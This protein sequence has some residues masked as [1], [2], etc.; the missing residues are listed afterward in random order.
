MKLKYLMILAPALA[1]ATSTA[2]SADLMDVYREAQQSDP[3]IKAALAAYQAT[4]TLRPQAKAG[5]L[6]NIGLGADFERHRFD[7]QTAT[8]G[9]SY[10]NDKSISL[11][12]RQP[13]YN[14]ERSVALKQADANIAQANAQYE[15]ARQSLA[16]RAAQGYFNVLAAR[17]ELEYAQ[18]EKAATSRQLEQSNK[19]F[20]VGMIAITDVNQT[21]AAYDAAVAA[22]ISA[23]NQ[24]ANARESLRELTGEYHEDLASLSPK[25]PL[26]LPVPSDM[27]AWTEVAMQQNLAVQA[28]EYAVD[29][30]RQEVDLQRAGHYPTLDA[31]ASHGYTD[32][33]IGGIFGVKRYD[34]SVGLE[35]NVP[36]YQGGGINARTQQA[37][38][39][40]NQQ[41]EQLDTQRRSALRQTRDAYRGVE[42]AIS[43]VKA[44]RQSI[45]SANSALEA[46]QAGYDVGTRTIVDVLLAQRDLFQSQ[47]D[48]AQARYNYIT[49]MLSLKQAAGTLSTDDLQEVNRWLVND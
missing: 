25:T 47:R 41:Q 36:I 28:A 19:R 8:G 13:L 48:Y 32:S 7:S 16:L 33:Q 2:W 20:E 5:L 12:L 31:T 11:N 44:L 4:Q 43:Q 6:P 45:K 46:T 49:N 30:A 29:V 22:E 23:E 17:A 9:V 37:A 1:L 14:R 26:V 27:T 34:T 18:S 40:L 15:S 39:L 21:Q 10:A 35:L 3:Q 24:L 42:T 38:Y